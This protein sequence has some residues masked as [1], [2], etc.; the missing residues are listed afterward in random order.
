MKPICSAR[1]RPWSL[2][3]PAVHRVGVARRRSTASRCQTL[4]ARR[5]ERRAKASEAI[6]WEENETA[7]ATGPDVPGDEEAQPFVAEQGRR[8]EGGDG[9]SRSSAKGSHRWQRAQSASSTALGHGANVAARAWAVLMGFVESGGR[10]SNGGCP[11]S[12][13]PR[14]CRSGVG[15]ALHK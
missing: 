11:E 5:R 10:M 4:A 12:R 15:Q 2:N 9:A 3:T 8:G 7:A 6:P 13:Q 14:R 1:G